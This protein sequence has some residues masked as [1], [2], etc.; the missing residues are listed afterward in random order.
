MKKF[1]FLNDYENS[2]I[3]ERQATALFEKCYKFQELHPIVLP[4]RLVSKNLSIMSLLRPVLKMYNPGV[5]RINA[6]ERSVITVDE[7]STILQMLGPHPEY[8]GTL[9]LEQFVPFSGSWHISDDVLRDI[10]TVPLGSIFSILNFVG[11]YVQMNETLVISRPELQGSDAQEI[12]KNITSLFCELDWAIHYN[13]L[14]E[15]LKNATKGFDLVREAFWHGKLVIIAQLVWRYSEMGW[16]RVDAKW[17]TLTSQFLK[18]HK[19]ENIPPSVMTMI[20]EFMDL[21]EA[22]HEEELIS[23]LEDIATTRKIQSMYPEFKI[24][25]GDFSDRIQSWKHLLSRTKNAIF[26]PPVGVITVKELLDWWGGYLDLKTVLLVNPI[27]S[28]PIMVKHDGGISRFNSLND[29]LS[30]L[31]YIMS[32]ECGIFNEESGQLINMSG[33]RLTIVKSLARLIASAIIYKGHTGLPLKDFSLELVAKRKLLKVRPRRLAQL[34][35]MLGLSNIWRFIPPAM[36]RAPTSMELTTPTSEESSAFPE[37]LAFPRS[38]AFPGLPAIAPFAQSHDS[39]S[40]LTV[41]T[42]PI[43][44][45]M[46]IIMVLIPLMLSF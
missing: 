15:I 18:S 10:Y 26:D 3:N 21:Y 30:G 8:C 13:R 43:V 20:L 24:I 31:V 32:S 38:S 35:N 33:T 28:R 16:P 29:L 41:P 40:N 22:L 42:A 5:I 25:G 39:L 34:R 37:S 1:H 6:G 46:T 19:P 44:L 9:Y 14:L 17:G 4:F 45:L 27:F 11:H 12:Y 7:F 23:S 36:I 2:M